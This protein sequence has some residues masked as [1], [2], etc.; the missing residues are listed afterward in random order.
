MCV[1]ERNRSSSIRL[2]EPPPPSPHTRTNTNFHENVAKYHVDT[3]LNLLLSMI[4]VCV[5]PDTV[6]AFE[7]VTSAGYA[8]AV[9]CHFLTYNA[10]YFQLW[11]T[12]NDERLPFYK[13]S[14]LLYSTKIQPILTGC[15]TDVS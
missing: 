1:S 5:I 9:S 7:E 15:R 11:R 6:L 13:E 4:F 10:V 14:R 3:R 12:V 2:S 8:F